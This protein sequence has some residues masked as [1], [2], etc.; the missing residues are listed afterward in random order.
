MNKKSHREGL[1]KLEKDT[2]CRR[3]DNE[4]KEVD[5]VAV[6]L[7]TVNFLSGKSC[8]YFFIPDP[9]KPRNQAGLAEHA[10]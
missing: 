7:K 8:L 9:N 10:I 4:D 5:L 3:R 1:A 2:G 6:N